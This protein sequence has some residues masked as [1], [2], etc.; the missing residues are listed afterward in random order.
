MFALLDVAPLPRLGGSLAE[1]RP[2][3]LVEGRQRRPPSTGCADAACRSGPS[4][5]V[6][7]A[8]NH[9]PPAH[10]GCRSGR[11]HPSRVSAA[12]PQVNA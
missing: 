12:T 3:R 10:L 8:T 2:E 9:G 11:G 5:V 4:M 7:P 6:V 1:H